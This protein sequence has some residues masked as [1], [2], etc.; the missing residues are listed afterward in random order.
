M[1]KNHPGK[2]ARLRAKKRMLRA[3]QA[4]LN[5]TAANTDDDPL[6]GLTNTQRVKASTIT[7]APTP[8]D[9][10]T[11]TPTDK[12]ARQTGHPAAP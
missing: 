5:G 4:L 1:S 3:T 6:A 12:K 7:L 10:L 11:P 8:Q 9:Q 2:N